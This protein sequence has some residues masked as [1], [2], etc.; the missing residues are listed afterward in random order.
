MRSKSILP[1]I[2][3]FFLCIMFWARPSVPARSSGQ[4][5]ALHKRAAV[6]SK[7][8]NRFVARVLNQEGIKYCTDR[9]GIVTRVNP[10]GKWISVR[11]VD[12]VPMVSK[13]ADTERLVGHEIFIFTE[14]ETIHLISNM[15]VK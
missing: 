12:V 5:R 15:E 7:R 4:V 3:V 6:V 8:K 2:L 1:V 11:E 9:H 14:G 13:G 10:A